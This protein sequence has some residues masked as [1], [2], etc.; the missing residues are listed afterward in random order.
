V[1]YVDNQEIISLVEAKRT[2][3]FSILDEECIMPRA[4]DKSFTAKVHTTHTANNCLEIPKITK[5]VK[6]KKLSKDEG[7]VVNHFAGQVTY[8][9]QVGYPIQ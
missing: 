3:I 8:N 4:T 1:D 2:G 6:G 5:D 7:F 9:T